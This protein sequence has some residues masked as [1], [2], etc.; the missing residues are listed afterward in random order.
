[1]TQ[2]VPPT[3][4]ADES[5]LP[6]EPVDCP[7]CGYDLT[8]TAS[9][10][11]SECGYLSVPEDASTAIRRREYLRK[12]PIKRLAP[13]A[14][15]ATISYVIV[16]VLMQRTIFQVPGTIPGW[17]LFAITTLTLSYAFLLTKFMPLHRRRLTRRLW[18]S[19]AAYLHAPFYA[20]IIV[21]LAFLPINLILPGT[22]IIVLFIKGIS[23]LVLLLLWGWASG[24]AY[25]RWHHLN[26]DLAHDTWW[27]EQER[28]RTIFQR[29]AFTIYTLN[30]LLGLAT[31]W[32][33][34]LSVIL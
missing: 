10:T 6:A 7:G 14:F 20:G 1:M 13:T 16:L 4:S 12:S 28:V 30:V 3:N 29:G 25:L 24:A 23:T 9:F 27:A 21:S 19:T 17:I 33:V 2:P 5:T 8:G 31:F 18:V 11:C 22:N 32:A 34:I 26:H 15:V